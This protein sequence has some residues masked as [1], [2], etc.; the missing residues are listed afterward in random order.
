MAN[1]AAPESAL[2][3]VTMRGVSV[4]LLVRRRKRASDRSICRTPVTS[5]DVP[6]GGQSL[7]L[8]LARAA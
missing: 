4:T 5:R 7:D 2:L 6:I 1:P 3:R 8:D